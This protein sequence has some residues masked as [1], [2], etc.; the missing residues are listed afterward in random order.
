MSHDPGEK[1]VNSSRKRGFLR[2]MAGV[3]CLAVVPVCFDA[4]ARAETPSEEQAFAHFRKGKA[5]MD[6][7]NPEEAVLEYDQALKL[8]TSLFGPEDIR[9]SAVL[10]DLAFAHYESGQ[11]DKAEPLYLRSLAIKESKPG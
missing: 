7:G 8:A 9:V 2:W 11:L 3:L 5:L 4:G 10:N 6:R 1:M